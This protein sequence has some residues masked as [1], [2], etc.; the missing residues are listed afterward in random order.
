MFQAFPSLASK[1]LVASNKRGRISAR[2]QSLSSLRVIKKHVG[3]QVSCQVSLKL[4]KQQYKYECPF[5]VPSRV[6]E[7]LMIP[8][9][10]VEELKNAPVKEVD[11]VATFY[12]VSVR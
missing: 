3:D 2:M 10:Y 9:R 4:S 11:T 12:E 6:G 1:S 8:A 7:R 5:Y